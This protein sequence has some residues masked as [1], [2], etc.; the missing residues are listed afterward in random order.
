MNVLFIPSWYPSVTDSL[1]GVFFREQSLALARNQ[2][3]LNIGISTWGQNDERLLLWG[4]EPF[5]SFSKIFL[6]KRLRFTKKDLIDNRVTEYFQPAFTWTS[7]VFHGN[8]KMII[9]ANLRNLKAFERQYRKADIIHAHV[10]FPAGHIASMISKDTGIP[11]VITEQMSPFPH[12]YFKDRAGRLMPELSK[13]YE[14]SAQNIAISS[15]LANE[16]QTQGVGKICVIPNLVDEIHFKPLEGSPARTKFSFFALGRLVQ[17]KGIDILLEAFAKSNV[18]AELRIGGDGPQ[19]GQYRK[20]ASD[21]KLD[22]KVAWLGALDKNQALKAYQGCDAFVLASRHESMGVVFAEAMACG[23]PV[24]GTICGGP[25]EFIDETTG[26]LVP[27]ENK[28][29]LAGAIKKMVVNCSQFDP[30]SIRQQFL[31][32]FSSAVVA[33][34]IRSVYDAVLQGSNQEI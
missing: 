20:L 2:P 32:R 1:P 22:H 5:R 15:A 11:Y 13:A 9:E 26:Y 28:K 23:K 24:I 8:M 27:P 21:L 25:E 19:A 17:Q 30:I 3:D 7:K 14:S 12:K 31:N 4:S 34:Q 10:G 6:H 33:R 16:M 18:D 29:A